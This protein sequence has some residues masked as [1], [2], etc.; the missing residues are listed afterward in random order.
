V[1][2]GIISSENPSKGIKKGLKKSKNRYFTK[3]KIDK[4]TSKSPRKKESEDEK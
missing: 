2:K 3:T 1:C 4:S